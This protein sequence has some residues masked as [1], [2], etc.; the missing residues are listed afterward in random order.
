M[1]LSL[2]RSPVFLWLIAAICALVAAPATAQFVEVSGQVGLSS[3]QK[4]SWGNPIWGDINNDGF[5]DLIVPT[6]GLA[7]SH[8]PFVYLN[9]G[10]TIFSDDLT[11]SNIRQAPSL[12]TRDWHGFSFGDYDGDGNLDLYIAEGAKGNQDGALKQ[13]LAFSRQRRW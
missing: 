4:K 9:L 8:G 10:G 7:L 2:E 3:L 5:L 12:D 11:N 6:H 13:D 1:F